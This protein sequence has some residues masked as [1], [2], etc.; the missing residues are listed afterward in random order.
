ME[1]FLM[2]QRGREIMPKVKGT[3]IK[4]NGDLSISNILLIMTVNILLVKKGEN[5]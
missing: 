1:Y 5:N 3:S 4:L 2:H